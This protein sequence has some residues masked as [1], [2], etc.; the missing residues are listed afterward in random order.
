[1]LSRVEPDISDPNLRGSGFR[2]QGQG[3]RDTPL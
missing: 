3:R 1:M 2:V